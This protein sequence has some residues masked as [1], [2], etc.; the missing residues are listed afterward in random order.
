LYDF[1]SAFAQVASGQITPTD[2]ECSWHTS[3]KK[4]F[5]KGTQGV[6]KLLFLCLYTISRV[7]LVLEAFIAVRSLPRKAYQMPD[8]VMLFP[9]L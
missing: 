2:R 9:H 8:W 4:L 3:V 5:P 1:P 6:L 7:F